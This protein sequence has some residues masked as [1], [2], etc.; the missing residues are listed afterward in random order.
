MSDP[1]AK[2]DDFLNKNILI[3]ENKA[4][5]KSERKHIHT[6]EFRAQREHQA[7]SNAR[8]QQLQRDKLKWQQQLRE[9][10][11]ILVQLQLDQTSQAVTTERRT[12]RKLHGH[13]AKNAKVLLNAYFY[14]QFLRGWGKG[15]KY[16]KC[17]QI[18]T[19]VCK[20]IIFKVLAPHLI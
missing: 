19:C 13:R 6:K 7:E 17:G 16:K 11:R 5:H 2:S 10:A 1:A 15:L 14:R 4:R 9:R 20:C 8:G 12:H 3:L 18:K